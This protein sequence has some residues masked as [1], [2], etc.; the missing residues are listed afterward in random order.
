[1]FEWADRY[2]QGETMTK[3]IIATGGSSGIPEFAGSTWVRLQY[4]LGLAELG[5]DA[6]WVDRLG[7]ID[8]RRSRH[9]LDYVARQF[10]D[11]ARAFNFEDRY[12][13]VY[14]DGESHFGMSEGE[15]EALMRSADLYLGISGQPRP[16]KSAMYIPVRAYV[17]VDPGFTQ[18]WASQ[19]DMSLDLYTHF[20][21]VGQ[22]VGRSEFR[23][24]TNEVDWLP[25]LP[26]V[27]LSFWPE[28]IDD[29][30]S[31]FS[32]VAD[33]RGSQE[34]ILGDEYL[35]GKRSEFVRFIDVPLLSDQR[36]ELALTV[37]QQDYEDIGLLDGHNWRIRDPYAYTGNPESYR[38]F[39][40]YS[41][42]EF[43]VAKNGYVRSNSGWISDRTACYLASGKPA[44]VQSTGF[45]WSL[46][47]GTG[48]LTY[49]SVEEAVAAIRT[50]NAD[51][52]N[53]A[54]AA[55]KLAEDYFDSRKV[56]GTVLGQLGL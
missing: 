43:S 17:D 25:M 4:L 36:M 52:L 24:P 48:L 18:A 19:Q 45:E 31:R 47:V 28:V 16:A 29:T 2:G 10:H 22:N 54:H 13:I 11:L 20:L 42:A 46:P 8:P 40:Q 56:L 7:P 15:L 32:T 30:C 51:Y 33:W 41:R 27:V 39:I 49:S 21:T 6:F 50:V 26:P 34:A 53:H 44:V 37:G 38:E 5:V 14:N 9:S 1:M 55:R 3:G 12:C 23:A 35:G